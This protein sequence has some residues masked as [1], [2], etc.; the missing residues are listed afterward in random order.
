MTVTTQTN[1]DMTIQIIGDNNSMCLR[2]LTQQMGTSYSS[3]QKLVKKKLKIRPNKV[4]VCQQL[5][6]GDFA[7][8]KQFYEMFLQKF[9]DLSF[10]LRVNFLG[11]GLVQLRRIR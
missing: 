4:Q 8:R 5:Q 6:P 1:V 10:Y 7:R 2:H 3:T 11:R 9:D